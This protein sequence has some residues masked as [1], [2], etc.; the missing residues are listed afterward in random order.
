[1]LFGPQCSKD[2]QAG[3][4]LLCEKNQSSTQ[5]ESVV[6]ATGG[7]WTAIQVSWV[8]ALGKVN[9][10]GQSDSCGGDPECQPHGFVEERVLPAL[11]SHIH[12]EHRPH[13]APE[14]QEETLIRGGRIHQNKKR[15]SERGSRGATAGGGPSWKPQRTHLSTSSTGTALTDKAKQQPLSAGR[16]RSGPCGQR[17]P[18]FQALAP[19]HG[20][21]P[22]V[23]PLAPTSAGWPS[24]GR[25]QEAGRGPPPLLLDPQNKRMRERKWSLKPPSLPTWGGSGEEQ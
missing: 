18:S 15:Y 4:H 2:Y 5:A 20:W 16:A 10:K 25:A 13:A 21:W 3:V 24:S 23:Q 6:S 8:R 11:L 14:G 19:R 9:V 1:M 12:T 17:L 7:A 22:P